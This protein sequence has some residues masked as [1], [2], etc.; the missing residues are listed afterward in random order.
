LPSIFNG[1][2][3]SESRNLRE[4]EHEFE[5]ENCDFMTIPEAP[6]SFSFSVN[7]SICARVGRIF[8][9]DVKESEKVGEKVSRKSRTNEVHVFLRIDSK[10]FDS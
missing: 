1:W 9:E 8:P 5:Y 4:H 6:F 10:F 3:E 7:S 2:S